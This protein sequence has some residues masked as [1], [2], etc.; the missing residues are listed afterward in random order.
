VANPFFNLAPSWAT[1]P[2]VVLATLATVIASQAVISGAYSVSRQAVRLGILPRMLV[3][4]TSRQ[5]AGQIYVPVINWVLFV[6]VVVLIAAFGSSSRLATAYGLAVTG[7][8]LL[9]S[10]LFLVLA[11]E[12]WRVERWKIVVYVVLVVALEMTFLA[13]KPDQDRQR[14]LAAAAH[15]GRGHHAHVHLASRVDRPAREGTRPRGAVAP[16]VTMIRDHDTPRVPGVAV[17]PHPNATTTPLALRANVDFNR[18]VHQHVI[19]AAP[20]IRTLPL[21]SEILLAYGESSPLTWR[22]T[23]APFAV[24]IQAVMACRVRSSVTSSTRV[25]TGC[26]FARTSNA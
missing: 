21:I 14:R 18:V 24:V 16:F 22:T 7:T 10:T 6:G 8:L 3:K 19:T 11:H 12:V 13:A 15:R 26:D 5:E 23:G 2:L 20:G 17:F 1:L 9:T 4:H 25:S